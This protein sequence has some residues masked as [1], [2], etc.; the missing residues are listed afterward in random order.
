MRFEVRAVAEHGEQDVDAAAG[1]THQGLLV[2]FALGLLA[3]VVGPGGRI[4]Q[5]GERGEKNARLRCLLPL[6]DGLSPRIEDPDLRVTGAS[7]A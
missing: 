1:Q 2:A 5:R 6:R 3:F 7:P 4:G